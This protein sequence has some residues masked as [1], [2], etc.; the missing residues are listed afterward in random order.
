MPEPHRANT[1]QVTGTVTFLFTDIEGSARLWEDEPERMRLALARHDAISRAAVESHRGLVVKSTGDGIHAAFDDALDALGAVV[2]LQQALADPTTNGVLL[3][4]RC[5]LHAGIVERRDNDFF[6]TAVNR[7]ARIMA[8][9]HGG[10]VLLSQAV[11]TL[12]NDRLIPGIAL[13]DLGVV[14]LRDLTSAA[15]VY[16]LLHPQLRADFPALRTLEATPNNLPQQLTS[17]IGRKRELTEAEN[18]LGRTRLLTLVG[19]GGIG[20][21][22]L[23]LQ[24]AAS[25][26]DQYSD[27]VWLVELAALADSR[28]VPLAVASVL[29]VT[30]VPGHPL[31]ETLYR[32]A[33]D[34][35]MLLI[36]DNCEHLLHACAELAKH[37]LQAG[38]DVR[39][40][41]SSREPMHLAGET[42]Y[43]V[44]A[45]TIPKSDPSIALAD[46]EQFEAANLF[47]D[48]ARSAQP[49]FEWTPQN[50]VAVANI[51]RRLDGIPLALELAAARVRVLSVE[52]IAAH[53]NNRFN[54]LTRGD[55]TALPRQQ[56]LRAMIDWS[57]ELLTE[58]ERALLRRL[59]VFA[60]GWTLE[61]AEAVG[62]GGN[63]S[64]TDVLGLLANLV[65]KS[66]VA[67]EAEGERY[68]LLETVRQYAQQKLDESV[69]ADQTRRRH[70]DFFLA[71]A[72]Q[73]SSRLV[74]PDQGA[75]L[76]RLDLEA[77]NILASHAECDRAEDGGELGLRLVFSIKLYLIYRGLL[78]LLLRLAIEAL[79]RPG[80]QGRTPARCRALH[81]AGQVELF[82][83][84]Y[85]EAHQ[86]LEES[87]SIA[88][89]IE[90]KE[91]AAM[92]LEELGVVCTGQGN[93]AEAREY[94]EEALNLALHLRNKRALASAL[95]A[96]AQLDRM[97]YRL[98]AAERLYERVLA[99]A[100]E[101]EDQEPIAIG[102]LNLAMVSIGRGSRDRALETLAEAL[103]IAAAIGSKRA[104]QSGLE[105]SAGLLA[106][107]GEWE[108]A[109]ILFG[110]AEAQMAH[111]G[112]R[113]DPADEVFLAPL[114]A[115]TRGA[116]GEPAFAAA[117]V[118]GRALA[119]D[120]ALAQ[121]RASLG[122]YR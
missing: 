86:Y 84:R 61:A 4:V 31:A 48:R 37:L 65:D 8:A 83:G 69:E 94:L 57:F 108:R 63:L 91:R 115:K 35:K 87:L 67:L 23:S 42:S 50:V 56:T 22:R 89:Q 25:V 88:K 92:V 18:L 81:A 100:R 113:R 17:F 107:S 103:T 27:G 66:L 28:D 54:L 76:A 70:L 104:G 2:D 120:V 122:E 55:T 51:C 47:I 73:A 49:A 29:G 109:A 26:M 68:R 9:A 96:L 102:L 118:A 36:L 82:M 13:R 77:E 58:H 21:T 41:A 99:L 119:Y 71:L 59:A 80:A 93:L 11:A 90:D 14:R 45:L 121:A 30:E 16:Q 97:E 5:G 111:T 10:Q 39:V 74:G 116:L 12:V 53:L 95:N 106:S 24:L 38:P 64:K 15:R 62:A 1:S 98:D 52:K 110:A 6:G 33:K 72:E 112:L 105:V 7:A 44:P 85:G 101:L 3:R 75:W 114:I 40:L 32:F 43:L 79:A 60:G 20:K 78:A 19:V 117:K 34:R 46:L